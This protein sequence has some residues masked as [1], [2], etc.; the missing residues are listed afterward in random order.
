MRR[1][2]L[3]QNHLSTPVYKV[4]IT[5][6]AGQIAYSFLPHLC[7]GGVL[8]NT[9]PIDLRL[10][11]IPSALQSVEGVVMELKDS[12]YHLI[13]SITVT[14][15]PKV[16]F[17]DADLIVFF[18]GFPRKEGMERKELISKNTNIFKEQGQALNQVGKPSTKCVV[19]ANPANTNC[20]ALATHAPNLP[21]ENFTCLT[22]LDQNR[23]YSSIAEKT[24]A[25]VASI[26]NII[27]WG[28]HSSTMYADVNQG[29]V[30]SDR[31]RDVVK[32]DQWL[33]TEFLTKVQQRGA[34]IIKARK[35]SSVLSAAS[36]TVDH[37]KDWIFGTG[38]RVVSMGVFSDGSYDV[39]TGIIFSFPVTCNGG[40]WN[41]VKGIQLDKFS[42]EKICVTT[43][44]LM[45]E[46]RDGLGA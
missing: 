30:A 16:A 40:N 45:E 21:K 1:L 42:M 43:R 9:Q 17:K 11:D 25:N 19:V 39:P 46:K 20:L 7:R 32:N 27:I 10:L 14:S 15:D 41:I 37:I 2:S 13:T 36:S 33:N 12:A 38:E 4:C 3:I 31:I 44:E 28:N 5:G 18:G 35:Q 26:K 29:T 24:G 23:A 34:A 8:G 6:A 22:R